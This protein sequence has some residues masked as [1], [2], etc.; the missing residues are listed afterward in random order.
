MSFEAVTH[1]LQV[2]NVSLNETKGARISGY[3][4]STDKQT[5]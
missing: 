5:T 1:V 3:I 2:N 4:I